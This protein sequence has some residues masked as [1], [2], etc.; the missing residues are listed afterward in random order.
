LLSF[1]GKTS[2]RHRRVRCCCEPTRNVGPRQGMR[3]MHNSR[4]IARIA[5]VK[6][7]RLAPQPYI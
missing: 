6:G 2:E 1:L 4:L 5:K 7:L 3:S